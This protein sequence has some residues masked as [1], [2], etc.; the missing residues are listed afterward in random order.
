MAT[1]SKQ[2][3]WVDDPWEDSC[4]ATWSHAWWTLKAA[5]LCALLGHHGTVY[6]PEHMDPAWRTCDRCGRK[7]ERRRRPGERFR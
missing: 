1:E 2:F 5:L 3:V 7:W 4:G 6:P